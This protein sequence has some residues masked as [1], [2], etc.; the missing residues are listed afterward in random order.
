MVLN[1][2]EPV[3]VKGL[4][5]KK[6]RMTMKTRFVSL[7]CAVV[8]LLSLA[9]GDAV[10]GNVSWSVSVFSGPLGQCGHWVDRPGYGRC[11]YPAYVS[12]DWR[13]YCEGY[14]MWTDSG[15]YWVSNEPWAWA[16]YHYGR[17]VYDPYYGWMWVPDTE[18]GPSWV[19][20]REGGEYVGWAPLPPGAGFGPEGYVVVR[21]HPVEDRFFVFVGIGHFAEP[22][23]RRTVIV[24]KTTIINQTVNITNITRVNNVVVNRG[25]K[26]ENIQRVSSRKLTEPP[27]HVTVDR[28]GTARHR[29]AMPEVLKPAA[30]EQPRPSLS[31]EKAKKREP[32]VIRGS[33]GAPPPAVSHTQPYEK[34]ERQRKDEASSSNKQPSNQ[35]FAA[36]RPKPNAP[37][38]PDSV[39]PKHRGTPAPPS[40]GQPQREERVVE[41]R[42]QS[43]Q[44]EG[45]EEKPK[46]GEQGGN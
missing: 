3:T 34:P 18:W 41:K 36:K 5:G 12:S 11:W 39:Q 1:I 13:P 22:I 10:A 42:G 33:P 37:V 43:H 27:P 7:V 2:R 35:N 40:Q 20:W 31:Q 14:W 26:L 32:E 17:W 29:E 23:H 30:G 21:D 38:E 44:E 6:G 24:N 25:P 15:W 16:T 4:H 8:G 45:R 9:A 19:S 46:K 28:A